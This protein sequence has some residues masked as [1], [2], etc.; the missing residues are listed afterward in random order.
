M[1]PAKDSHLIPMT[2]V[3]SGKGVDVRPDVYCYTD[4]IVNLMF[5]GHP[6]SKEGWVLV[7]AGM[8]G[9]AKE[10]RKVAAER[11]GEGRSPA[12]IIL[13]H[14]HFDHTGSLVDLLR[15]WPVP[16][17][18]HPAEAPFLTGQQAYP[19]PDVTVEGGL[20]A[21]ISAI[22]PHEPV[23]I[24]EV[25]QALPADGSVPHMPGWRWIHVP[26][27]A[28]GQV[29]L[30]RPSDRTLIS[31]DAFITVRQ[32]S[33]YKVLLQKREVNGPPR[34]LTTDWQLAESSVR[35]LAGL[36]PN[37]VAPGHGE[38]MAGEELQQ[39]LQHLL[40]NWSELAVPDYGRFVKDSDKKEAK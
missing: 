17:Y 40:A 33:F 28:P 18:A 14:G 32:D 34:Y 1:K 9:S 21:K 38:P 27:H 4:Q 35:E 10:L 13:T 8:P 12:A 37:A 36:Q 5:I 22:Y 15:D 19:E 7:D 16:V 25:L 23:D 6:G 3:N 26:G 11:F 2:S 39:G 24:R 20:L 30:F 29:A 31:A